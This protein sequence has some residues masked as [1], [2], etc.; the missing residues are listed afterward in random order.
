M[1]GCHVT[2]AEFPFL[3]GFSAKDRQLADKAAKAQALRIRKAV[4]ANS[5]KA[6]Q[7]V[8][9][10][11]RQ[12]HDLLGP[13]NL[14]EL[15]GAMMRERLQF[16]DLVQPPGG[17][18]VDR[19]KAGQ[20]RKRRVE[21]LARKLGASSDKLRAIGDE[22]QRQLDEVLGV[23]DGAVTPGFHLDTNRDQWLKLSPFHKFPLPWG[24]VPDEPVDGGWVVERPPFFGFLMN[25]SIQQTS[26]FRSDY[27]HVLSPPAGQVGEIVTM[28]GSDVGDYGAA[29]I[30]VET[31]IA[32]GFVAPTAGL[33]EVVI[34]AQSTIGRHRLRTSD[35]WGWS[36]GW[37]N[38]NNYLMLNVLHPNVPEPSLAL[39]SNWFT[40]QSSDA[41]TE[42]ENLV[43]GQH[44]FAHLFSSGPVPAGQ[45]VVVVIGSRTFDITR[46]NDVETH[47]RTNFQWS[48]S[49][50]E[51][52][53][54]P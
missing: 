50:V 3:A 15:R 49:S 19:I 42:F 17:L 54:S 40:R 5:D 38:Q 4:D 23:V 34:D 36:N 6:D 16:R 52:R 22:A 32:F 7:I 51:V 2:S 44:Y 25:H 13:P 53:I 10:A 46:A 48:I 30:T 11:R 9:H 18:T 41:T 31:D 43:R 8:D 28:D 45:S 24:V 1:P 33:V 35:E 21:A 39:M 20:A 14:A 37:T 26:A 12:T 47:S 29:S 27:E